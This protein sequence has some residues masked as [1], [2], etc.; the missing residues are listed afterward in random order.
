MGDGRSQRADSMPVWLVNLGCQ[1][2]LPG[3]WESQL[4]NYLH[5]LIREGATSVE[6]FLEQQRKGAFYC[7]WRHPGV[8]G[9]GSDKK[10]S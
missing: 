7:V 2:D 6:H 9:P 4:R 8:G 3:K 10:G 5:L 1:V